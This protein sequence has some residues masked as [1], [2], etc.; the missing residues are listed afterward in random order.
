[1]KYVIFMSKFK[2]NNKLQEDAEVVAEAKSWIMH[3]CEMF[4]IVDVKRNHI[5]KKLIVTVY[6]KEK[7][8]GE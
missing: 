4:D 3:N 7:E 5:N 1:M 8:I 2:K 6:Y